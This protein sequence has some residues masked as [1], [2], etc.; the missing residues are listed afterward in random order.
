MDAKNEFLELRVDGLAT[1]ALRGAEVVSLHRRE[2]PIYP[3]QDIPGKANPRQ[4]NVASL[5]TMGESRR[6]PVTPSGIGVVLRFTVAARKLQLIRKGRERCDARGNRQGDWLAALVTG[7]KR[8][9]RR[10]M[11]SARSRPR[12]RRRSCRA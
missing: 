3:R 10:A 12:R 9:A 7:T 5:P 11:A 6:S 4:D 2:S 1:A 8:L